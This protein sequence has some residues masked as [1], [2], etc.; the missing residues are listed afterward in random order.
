MEISRIYE[1]YSH[2]SPQTDAGYI[3]GMS[4]METLVDF[5]YPSKTFANYTEKMESIVKAT[6]AG[7]IATLSP[8]LAAES[9]AIQDAANSII[10]KVLNFS[11]DNDLDTFIRCALR[12][13]YISGT[14]SISTTPQANDGIHSEESIYGASG[15]D[16]LSLLASLDAV[17]LTKDQSANFKDRLTDLVNLVAIVNNT[18]SAFTPLV[19]KLINIAESYFKMSSML[20]ELVLAAQQVAVPISGVQNNTSDLIQ[21]AGFV[22]TTNNGKK[23]YSN[24]EL[25]QMTNDIISLVEGASIMNINGVDQIS[26]NSDAVASILTNSATPNDIINLYHLANGDDAKI[27]SGFDGIYD[28]LCAVANIAPFDENSFINNTRYQLILTDIARIE[29]LRTEGVI[30]DANINKIEAFYNEISPYS[31]VRLE[32]NVATISDAMNLDI[33]MGSNILTLSVGEK[34][35]DRSVINFSK[36]FM[37]PVGTYKLDLETMVA[38]LQRSNAAFQIAKITARDV[39]RYLGLDGMESRTIIPNPDTKNELLNAVVQIVKSRL[40]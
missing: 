35:R 11:D 22:N 37:S 39:E 36:Q 4:P 20:S 29:L 38:N 15:E 25:N 23:E 7:Q 33:D 32:G 17:E 12:A 13:S 26:V 6:N 2:V 30:T 27:T 34:L 8:T 9:P 3:S 40:V 24:A 1:F 16:I 5:Y 19:L 10:Y 28:T 31:Q 14:E 21:D 18:N